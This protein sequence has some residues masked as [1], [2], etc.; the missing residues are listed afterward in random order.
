MTGARVAILVAVGTLAVAAPAP[1]ATSCDH[2]S[3]TVLSVELSA[4]GD[5]A[6]LVVSLDGTILVASDGALIACTGTGGTPTVTNT[7][8]I[9]V[10]NRP[11]TGAN[12]VYIDGVSRFAPGASAMG[13]DGG[14]A[15][16]EIHVNLNDEP[17]SLLAVATDGRGGRIRFGFSGINTNAGDG[18]V[19]PDVDVFLHRVSHVIGFG[20]DGPD[21]LDATGGAGT[22]NAVTDDIALLGG[23]GANDITGG[24][25]ADTLV[26]GP[27]NDHLS[28]RGGNDQLLGLAGADIL[29]SGSGDDSVDGGA[30]ADTVSYV[31]NPKGISVDLAIGGPQS[32]GDGIGTDMLTGVEN[33]LGSGFAD[34][35]RGDDASNRLQGSDGNDV[36][37]GRGG[38]DELAG[39][40][41]ADLLDVRDGG[42][43]VAGCGTETDGVIADRPGIDALTACENIAFPLVSRASGAA[44]GAGDGSGR[45]TGMADTRPPS[46]LGKVRAVPARFEVGPRATRETSSAAASKGTTFRYSLSEAATVTFAIERKTS[47]QKVKGACRAKTRPGAARRT[48]TLFK[49]VGAFRVQAAAGP[50]RKHFSGRIGGTWLG[51]GSYRAAVTAIDAA[52][53]ASNPGRVKLEV[54]KR[55]SGPRSLGS[56]GSA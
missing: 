41:G 45:P 3:T 42:P 46:F 56:R 11:G 19:Q 24:D 12:L 23:G 13:E 16:I 53:H 44:I 14:T 8:V 5:D 21:T 9:S 51:P 43:D 29:E 7:D 48:C 28:G 30:G 6:R 55:R 32:K 1:A 36:L 35:V 50:N 4:A 17:D 37:E 22:G 26:G 34:V 15:E 38:A 40:A 33:V 2:A 31:Q 47:G 25:G 20:S 10:F 39:D 27:G 18:E 52:G 54:L 49:R